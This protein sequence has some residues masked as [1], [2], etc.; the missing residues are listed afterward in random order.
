[1][2]LK[3]SFWP[4]ELNLRQISNAS[5]FLQPDRVN[6]RYFKLRLFDLEISKVYD[7]GLQRFRDQFMAKILFL[8]SQNA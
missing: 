7:T 4:K 5:I 3:N 8:S 6:L 1:M 2:E